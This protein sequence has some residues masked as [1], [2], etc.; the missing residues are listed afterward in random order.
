M[1]NQIVISIVDSDKSEFKVVV[2]VFFSIAK[3]VKNKQQPA[4]VKAWGWAAP[5]AAAPPLRRAGTHRRG[6]GF[7][8]F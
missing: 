4:C 3:R 2:I 6:S 7:S 8:S 5:A 1:I